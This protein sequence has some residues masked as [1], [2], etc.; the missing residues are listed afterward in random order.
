[1][2]LLR[3]LPPEP[4]VDILITAELGEVWRRCCV[5]RRGGQGSPRRALRRLGG[6]EETRKKDDEA[7]GAGFDLSGYLGREVVRQAGTQNGRRQV[8]NASTPQRRTARVRRTALFLSLNTSP[9]GFCPSR[10]YHD[11]PCFHYR[12]SNCVSDEERG[13]ARMNANE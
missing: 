12:A 9:P 6:Q 11:G 8:I 5:G 2:E 4:A 13:D 10:C 3:G 1:M 7:A